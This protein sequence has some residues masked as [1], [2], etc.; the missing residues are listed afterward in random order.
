ML[1]DWVQC[2]R[3]IGKVIHIG[4]LFI[5]ILVDGKEV[6]KKADEV[7]PIEL[8]PEIL[9]K[10]G[11]ERR[12]DLCKRMDDALPFILDINEIDSVIVEWRDSFDNGLS[13]ENAESWGEYWSLL[14]S[15]MNYHFK[16]TAD[17]I[18]IHDLQHALRLC[19]IDKEIVV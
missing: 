8:T 16:K 18:Y 15:G 11:F 13:D 4:I 3:G 2:E 9:E 14:V 5:V 7:Q 12:D 19:G 1:R 17:R 6:L 10:N